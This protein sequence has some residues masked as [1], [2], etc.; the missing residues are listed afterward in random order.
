MNEHDRKLAEALLADDAALLSG[1]VPDDSI[2]RDIA[3][4]FRGRRGVFTWFA[5]FW[6]FV[7]AA[8]MFYGGYRFFVTDADAALGAKL[9]W[10]LV[11]IFSVLA[12]AMIKIWAWMEIQRVGL[13]R[14]LKRIELRVAMLSGDRAGSE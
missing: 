13:Q 12:N 11:C 8:L 10:G 9:N 7:F 4:T 3:G 6:G 14:E 2:F 5:W 1:E